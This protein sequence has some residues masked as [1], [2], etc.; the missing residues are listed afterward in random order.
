MENKSNEFLNNIV[1]E[2][3]SYIDFETDE[4]IENTKVSLALSHIINIFQLIKDNRINDLKSYI[5]DDIAYTDNK[6]YSYSVREKLAIE[7]YNHLEYIERIESN[8]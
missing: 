2:L 5:N 8:E 7:I 6:N 3:D 4:L 1:K